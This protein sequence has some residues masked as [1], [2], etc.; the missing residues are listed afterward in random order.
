VLRVVVDLAAVAAA[1]VLIVALVLPSAAPAP[2][3]AVPTAVLFDDD[4]R[5]AGAVELDAIADQVDQVESRLLAA[6]PPVPEEG[7]ATSAADSEADKVFD[8]PWLEELLQNLS[9]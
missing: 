7:L 6:L 1:A 5:P 4:Y 2:P 9:S 8:D 3:P